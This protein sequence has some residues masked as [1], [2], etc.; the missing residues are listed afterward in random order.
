M[1][2]QNLVCN[3][4]FLVAELSDVLINGYYKYPLGYDIV[5]WFVIEV[6]KLDDKMVFCFK[7][8]N[9]HITMSEE[10]GEQKKTLPFVDFVKKK[11][12]VI[13]LEIVVI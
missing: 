1:Y 9:K 2:R 11:Y 4:F 6:M 8:I 13:K 7:K 10:D 12:F 3:A 5:D